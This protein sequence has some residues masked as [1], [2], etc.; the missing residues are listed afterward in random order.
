M[1]NYQTPRTL[2]ECSFTVG[3]RTARHERVIGALEVIGCVACFA[4][5]GVML[6]WRG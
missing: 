2:A 3:Y 1:R 4:L 5:I 6:A